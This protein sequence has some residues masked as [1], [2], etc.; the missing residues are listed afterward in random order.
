MQV[1]FYC[2]GICLYSYNVEIFLLHLL[3]LCP[4][5]YGATLKVLNYLCFTNRGTFC[6]IL[7]SLN[8]LAWHWLRFYVTLL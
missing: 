7:P 1:V 6:L 2:V 4:N 3:P 5:T 8:F